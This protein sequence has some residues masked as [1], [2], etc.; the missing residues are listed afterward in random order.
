MD[1]QTNIDGTKATVAVEGNMTVSTA[2]ELEAVLEALPAEV[3]DVD[4]D[5][6]NLV[7]VASAGLRVIVAQAKRSNAAGGTM[8]LLHPNEEVMEVLDVTGLLEVLNVES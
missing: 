7:Y 6:T 4:L 5:L 8:R 2:P 3:V 1:V